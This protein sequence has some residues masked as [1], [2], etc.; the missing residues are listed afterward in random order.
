MSQSASTTAPAEQLLVAPARRWLVIV[1]VW[2]VPAFLAACETWMFWRLGN[3]P[4]AFWRAIALEAP[5]WMI[6][7]L[8]TP[9][10][11]ALGRRLPLQRPRIGR[12]IAAHLGVSLT[13]AA[14][15]AAVAT[16]MMKLF[17]LTPPPMPFGRMMLSWYLSGLPLTTLTYFGTL[18]T[19]FALT[20]FAESRRRAIDAERLTAQLA[21]ARLGALRMQLHPHFLFNTLNAITV[22]ARD[23]DTAAVTRML[24]LLSEL[25]RDVLRTD[26][27]H[28]IALDAELDFARRYLEVELVRFADRLRVKLD[29]E[30]R[31][32]AARVP[33]FVLQPLI[34]NALRHGIAPRGVGGAVEIGARIAEDGML[35]LWV[36]DDGM[37]LPADW[38]GSDDYGIGLSNTAARVQG[39]HGAVGALVVEAV[40]HGGTRSLLRIPAA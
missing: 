21:E 11:F 6:Y 17:M 2:S 15:Y 10:I 14:L 39:L 12:H 34:E 28:L 30:D 23:G 1:G 26:T 33:A 7:A 32:R 29:V 4:G 31:A 5:A 36:S 19:G 27:G 9:L 40:A 18:G 16:A 8:L 37:G 22:L 13:I 35:E 24:T 3:R 38:G 25:L 20:Y